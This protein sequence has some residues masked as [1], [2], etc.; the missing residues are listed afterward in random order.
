MCGRR[1]HKA[2]TI[3]KYMDTKDLKK[4]K[5]Y[6]F[7]TVKEKGKTRVIPLDG[8]DASFGKIDVKKY[9]SVPK[10]IR[11]TYK[12]GSIFVSDAISESTTKKYYTCPKGK[13][14]RL[15][16]K[17]KDIV[18]EYKNLTH[19]DYIDELIGSDVKLYESIVSDKSLEAPSSKKDGFYMSDK[20]W[21]ILVRNIKR[22]V[23]TMIIGPT[24]CGKTSCVKEVCQR[25]GLKLS[26]FDMGSIIDPISSLLGVH[27]LK[28]GKSVF[29]YANFTQAIQEP[30][31]ILLDELSRASLASNN[32]L[33]PCLDDRRKLSIEIAGSDGVREIKVHPEVTFIATAN[34]GAEYTGTNSMDR[35]LVNRFFPL[36]LSNIP[37]TEEKNVLC[38]RTGIDESNSGMIVKVAN[39]IRDLA[40][41]QEISVS[42]SIRETLMVA[43]LVCDGWDIGTAME[44]VFI[45]IYEGTATEGERSIIYKTIASY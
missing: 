44:M 7:K 30:G 21:R 12:I 19:D 40:I 38:K 10:S 5:H 16:G 39:N 3:E 42:L 26:V 4:E 23:N 8:Q 11:D 35:A 6:F 18:E 45:P 36:E 17:M 31:I 37:A 43:S 13:F 41:K 33:F 24:G 29:D 32:V 25:M 28:G 2:H 22:H 14:R 20:D 9:C 1:K 15:S 27:R 34:I